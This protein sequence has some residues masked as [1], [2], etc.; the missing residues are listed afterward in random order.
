MGSSGRVLTV[1][2][3]RRISSSMATA[4]VSLCQ[5]A[6]LNNALGKQ[7]TSR[8]SSQ[9]GS[10]YGNTIRRRWIRCLFLNVPRQYRSLE[11]IAWLYQSCLRLALG[12]CVGVIVSGVDA[13]RPFPLIIAVSNELSIFGAI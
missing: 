9:P 12:V 7:G 5:S 3:L 6:V 1:T 13:F 10:R 11:Q 8:A 2:G 4:A